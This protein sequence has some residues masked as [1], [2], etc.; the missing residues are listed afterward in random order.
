M[1]NDVRA[2]GAGPRHRREPRPNT[3]LSRGVDVARGALIGTVETVP[4]VSGGTVALVVGVYETIITSAGHVL[5]GLRLALADL[6][7]GRGGGRAREE[8]ARVEWHVIVPLLIGMFAALVVM[9]RLIEGWV[10]DNPVQSRGLFFGLVLAS[11][12]VPFSLASRAPRSPDGTSGPWSWREIAVAAGAGIV[13]FVVVSLP[14]GQVEPDPPFVLLAAALAVSALVLPG[15]SGSF[16]LLTFG[17]YE[18][19]L[20]AVNERDFGY[21][22]VFMLGAA[23]G[24]AS[25]VK[26]LQ[27]LLE[28]HRRLT[29]VVLTGVMAGCLRALWPW[30]DED[31]TL[32]APGDHLGAAVGLA[33]L[34]FA[35]VAAFV[36]VER[37]WARRAG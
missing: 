5:S 21:L 34:G 12:A 1:P 2:H 18:D 20:S 31:R 37:R 22:G 30:Q 15:L 32:L 27:W 28:N 26:L 7:R 35:V 25:F 16:I 8:F 4:G 19:T 6:P 29:L 36:V 10:E 33:A 11:L 24:L 13:A 23:L 3:W 9:A 17:L 14:P